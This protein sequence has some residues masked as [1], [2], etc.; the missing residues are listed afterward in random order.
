M[1][2][3]TPPRRTVTT[4][5]LRMKMLERLRADIQ[6]RFTPEGVTLGRTL[7]GWIIKGMRAAH[8]PKRNVSE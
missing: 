5:M 3:F 8:I 1:E 2:E 4:C 6:I 7:D